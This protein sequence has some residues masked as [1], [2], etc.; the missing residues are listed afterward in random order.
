MKMIDLD[1]LAIA[2]V[3]RHKKLGLISFQPG[4]HDKLEDMEEKICVRDIY[5]AFHYVKPKECFEANCKQIDYYWRIT[6]KREKI[7]G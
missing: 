7:K 3:I 4:I 1:K 2:D 5:G 6:N